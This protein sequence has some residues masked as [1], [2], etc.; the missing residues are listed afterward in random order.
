MLL[1]TKSF[2]GLIT[3][4]EDLKNQI[5][6]S[7]IEHLGLSS[8]MQVIVTLWADHDKVAWEKQERAF[9]DLID[10]DMTLE[11]DS[12]KKHSQG[13]VTTSRVASRIMGVSFGNE[14]LFRNE[15]HKRNAGYVPVDLL[16]G[17]FQEIRQGLA[18]RAAT[19]IATATSSSATTMAALT[20]HLTQIP[21]FSSDLGCSA[22]QIVD[23]A[24][25]VMSSIHPFFAYTSAEEATDW[26]FKN[27]KIETVQAASGKPATISEVGWPSG[28]SSANLGKETKKDADDLMFG[29]DK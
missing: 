1:Y 8:D 16:E 14:V 6:L 24:D 21:V 28:P 29:M 22:H 23:S 7:V 13:S 2:T 26:T 25:W 9:W 18:S 15:G 10:H 11:T 12:R 4:R 3:R 17:Y 19:A 20:Q 27:F 5:N